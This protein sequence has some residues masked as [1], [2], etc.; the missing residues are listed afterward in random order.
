MSGTR[1]MVRRL[2]LESEEKN[3]KLIPDSRDKPSS[4]SV[5]KIVCFLVVLDI[6]SKLSIAALMLYL[7]RLVG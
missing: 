7:V 2:R 3:Q 1:G 4:C 6:L 5:L